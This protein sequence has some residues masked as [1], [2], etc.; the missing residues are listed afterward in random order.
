M[1]ERLANND[2]SKQLLGL[3]QRLIDRLQPLANCVVSSNP[4]G[5]VAI[6]WSK[7]E[8][9][10][11]NSGEIKVFF[12]EELNFGGFSRDLNPD[13]LT[14]HFG[15][16]SSNKLSPFVGLSATLTIMAT[17]NQ[18]ARV[19]EKDLFHHARAN[20]NTRPYFQRFRKAGLYDYCSEQGRTSQ[21]PVVSDGL[22]HYVCRY[23]VKGIDSVLGKF[24]V[25]GAV[26]EIIKMRRE[27]MEDFGFEPPRGSVRDFVPE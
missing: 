13:L 21:K 9:L 2:L 5:T 24:V 18:T 6:K 26:E 3:D 11:L 15:S 1:G 10:D 22:E 17:I 23:P 8:G 12:M 27:R 20:M 25:D 19:L 7:S 4:F 16:L 14:S